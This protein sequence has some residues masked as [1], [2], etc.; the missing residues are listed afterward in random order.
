[1]S[2]LSTGQAL[3][4]LKC[5]KC[6]EGDLFVYKNPYKLKQFHKMPQT[7]DKCG[8]CFEPEPGFYT[9]AM[10]VNYAFAVIITAVSYLVLEIGLKV[11]PIVF[12]SLYIS[13]IVLATPLLFRY[14]RAIFLY[15]VVR[16]D[17]SSIQRHKVQH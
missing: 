6:H 15:M 16:Y 8:E 2:T 10:Y 17:S 12:F 4:K 5:P 11:S 13:I 7:C 3:A 14:S 1:M 9:G